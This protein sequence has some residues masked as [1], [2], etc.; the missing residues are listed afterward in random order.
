MNNASQDRFD[1]P[2]RSADPATR[3]NPSGQSESAWWWPVIV[4]PAAMIAGALV[5]AL[6]AA[7][8]AATPT[9]LALTCGLIFGLAIVVRLS[10]RKRVGESNPEL[11]SAPEPLAPAQA[12]RAAFLEAMVDQ[13]PIMIAHV[14]AEGRCRFV[15]A[16]FARSMACL[17]SELVGETV[18]EILGPLNYAEHRHHFDASLAGA[19]AKFEWDHLDPDRGPTRLQT[20][21]VVKRADDGVCAGFHMFTLDITEQTSA[22]EA[23]RRAER[24]VRFII[25]QIPV[26]VTYIDADYRYRY[27]NRAQERWLGKTFDEVVGRG[28]REVIG[29]ALWADV[30]PNLK[31]ALAG[32]TVNIERERIDQK[33]NPIW[34][35][36]QHVPDV[37]EDGAVVGTY[38]VFFDITQRALAERALHESQ[39]ELLVAKETAEAASKAKSQFLAN[40][41][42][43]IRTPMNG[44]LGMAELLLDT[45]LDPKQRR[46]AQTIH[47]SG[48]ALLGIINDILDF[49]KIEAGKMSIEHVDFDLRQLGEEVLELLADRAAHR[50]VELTCQI[51]DELNPVFA[52]D[53]LRLRQVL[54]NLVGNAVKFTERGEVSVE[55]LPAPAAQLRAR[56]V[57]ADDAPSVGI[58]ARVRDTGIGMSE[59][60]LARLFAA[61][62]Q[63]DGSTTRKFGGTGLGLAISRQLVEMMGGNIG[64]ESQPGKGSTFWFTVRLDPAKGKIEKRPNNPAL[65]GVRALIVEDNSTNRAIL[66]HHLGT[67]G[68]RI[69]AAEHGA[70]ALEALCGAA[71]RGEPYQLVVTDQKMPVMDGLALAKAVRADPMLRDVPIILL[72]SVE[73]V[74]LAAA[75]RAAGIAAHL[76]KP[77]RQSE[78]VR[79]IANA[80]RVTCDVTD[81]ATSKQATLGDLGARILLVEDTAV[82]QSI[83]I[84]MLEAIGC[85]VTCAE[86]GSVALRLVDESPFDLILMDC[87]MPVM[88]GY[89]AT[90]EIRAREA[91][92]APAYAGR[93]RVPIIALTAH[94]MQGDRERCLAAGMDDY[95]PKPYSKQQL[96]TVLERWL[97]PREGAAARVEVT[98][99]TRIEVGKPD[100][101]LIDFAAIAVIRQLQQP[102]AAD[103]VDRVVRTY[104]S[105][106]PKLIERM[107]ASLQGADVETLIRSA[108]SL[109]SSSASVGVMRLASLSKEVE[110]RARAN[111]LANL[112]SMIATIEAEYARSTK[113]LNELVGTAAAVV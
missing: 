98:S 57:N 15:N 55:I 76:A 63:A 11:T 23:A 92:A 56:D 82:N 105:D 100:E 52:G 77:V 14:D 6:Y 49:S 47:R 8:A 69:D 91:R 13:L 37:N 27:I 99:E 9:L 67:L 19:P 73:S 2:R 29:D 59:E 41:S 21:L 25:D 70:R 34:H 26:T 17:P 68:M 101:P 65:A 64:A 32:E 39:N 24:R 61:F 75:A 40:M 97:R 18:E 104:C 35:S 22:I 60:T 112:N 66:Q 43:E 107:R 79:A 93:R 86:D 71:S 80:L 78:L 72:T 94:A 31:A 85:G 45:K 102:G 38:T 54:T 51:S 44:V 96:A 81:S 109:K 48:G 89:A 83:G 74:D 46:I 7:R 103:V 87:Q 95:L 4:I 84:M 42:H 90:A 33:G 88:D 10:R 36:G 110:M 50:G 106:A 28:V 16:S 108:H 1:A 5:T 30:E 58:L 12:E 3:D 111:D 62:S 53:P 20:E 113:A